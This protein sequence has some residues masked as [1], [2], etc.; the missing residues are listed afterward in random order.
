MIAVLDTL[1]TSFAMVPAPMAPTYITWSPIAS[2]T[3][4]QRR[5]GASS[6]P[7]Q[8]ASFPLAAP[9][10]PPL[11]GAS[12]KSTPCSFSVAWSFRTSSTELVVRSN[13]AVPL[14]SPAAR[15]SGPW[16][17]ASTSAG[18]GKDVKTM[19]L[20]CANCRGE[21]AHTA[22]FARCEAAASRDRSE[23]VSVCP[24]F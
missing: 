7:I 14:R 16:Q 9:P 24:A 4:L 6:P 3:G 13:Q 11:T 17:T 1:C 23:T 18:V 5:N 21:S 10:G 8:S 20:A 22:P 12:R 2:R 15:P 19:S